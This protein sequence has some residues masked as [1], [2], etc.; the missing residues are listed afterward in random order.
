MLQK[1]DHYALADLSPGY[2]RVPSVDGLRAF[3]ILL[4]LF[5]HFASELPGKP[6]FLAG[7][8]GVQ[9]FFVISGF[10]ITRLLL[11]EIGQTGRIAIRSF[12]FRRFVRLMPP[13]CAMLCV[14][15]A[16]LWLY[17]INDFMFP[18]CGL[19]YVANYC[20]TGGVPSHA[21]DSLW[22][23]AVEEH[24]YILF[25]LLL[26]TS[27]RYGFR[28]VYLCLLLV[29]CTA[30]GARI[31]HA[32]ADHP[33]AYMY[34]HTE[35]V[36]DIII[37]G[38]AL[39]VMSSHAAGRTALRR[40]SST[41]VF[42]LAA[43]LYAFGLLAGAS[44]LHLAF[45]QSALSVWLAVLL[46]NVLCNPDLAR[47]RRLLNHPAMVWIGRISYSTYLWQCVVLLLERRYDAIVNV[48]WIVAAVALSLLLGAASYY[49][50]EK[51]AA[52]RRK[53]WSQ[54]LGL[55]QERAVA[56]PALTG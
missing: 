13:L 51:P 15:V 20:L 42:A 44:K 2:D 6:E 32:L 39:S 24:F 54:L 43:V 1:S 47:I 50:I 12:Y 36:M 14:T 45:M 27:I 8:L 28:A 4:V 11:A 34:W 46:I 37:A 40:L 10:L 16:L 19:F 26:V 17:R 31:A 21:L 23:L 53:A 35:C 49:C 9:I 55:P 33:I 22:S 5:S 30:L 38:C 52:A 48:Y 29:F 56:K 41:P 18:V 3:C 7:L 25:P